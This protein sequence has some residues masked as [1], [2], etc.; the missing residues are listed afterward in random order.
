MESYNDA[1]LNRMIIMENYEHPNKKVDKN[2]DSE[3]Y[4][5]F[6][7]NSESCIDNLTTF[8]KIKDGVIIDAVF[9]GIGCAVSTASTNIFCNLIVSKTVEESKQILQNYNKMILGEEYQHELLG[10]LNVF[11]NVH[12]QA[13]RIKCASIGSDAITNII[14]GRTND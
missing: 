3:E 11:S 10:D 2:P 8:L 1:N 9:S 12:K 4:K 6:N 5:S 14:E 13:N 7:N